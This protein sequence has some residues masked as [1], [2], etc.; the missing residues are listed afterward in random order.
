MSY[1]DSRDMTPLERQHILG[2]IREEID[3]QNKI[4]EE[5]NRQIA[6]KKSNRNY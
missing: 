2:F 4:I 3:R 5:Q 6:S 1:D